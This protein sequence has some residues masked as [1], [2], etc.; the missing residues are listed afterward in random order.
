MIQSRKTYRNINPELLY[1][2]VGDL[3]MKQGV[4]L[5]DKKLETYALPGGSSHVSRGT[6]T[7]S[8]RGQESKSGKECIRVHIVGSPVGETKMILDIDDKV[9]RPASVSALEADLDFILGSYE[10]KQ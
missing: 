2:E 1:D 6:L 4:T 9:F 10:V 3:I 7:F 5:D 8:M